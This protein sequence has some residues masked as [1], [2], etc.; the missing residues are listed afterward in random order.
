MLLHREKQVSVINKDQLF[1]TAT[2]NI[3]IFQLKKYNMEKSFLTFYVVQQKEVMLEN[4]GRA[5]QVG[6][7]VVSVVASSVAFGLPWMWR[8]D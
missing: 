4:G 3:L 5:E 6:V 2:A 1:L 7:C 8:S